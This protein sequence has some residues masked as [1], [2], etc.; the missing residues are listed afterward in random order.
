MS[1]PNP[2]ESPKAPTALTIDARMARWEKTRARGR[3]RFIRVYG[4]LGWGVSTAVFW[5]IFMTFVQGWERLL[6]VLP[7]ALV[8][9][10]IGGYFFGSW[11]WKVSENRY[12]DYCN[13]NAESTD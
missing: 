2:Y 7:F 1:D 11:A 4:V 6:Q 12:R 8:A 13:Q 10:P 9:F 3:N 5:S